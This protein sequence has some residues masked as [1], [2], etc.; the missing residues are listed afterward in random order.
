MPRYNRRG[1]T[2][3]FLVTSI[4]N[5]AAPTVAEI[6]AGVPLHDV[7]RAFNGFTSEIED[8]DAGDQG[9]TFNKTI[10]GGETAEAS[11]MTFYAGDAAADEE[12][13]VRAA[14]VEGANR[15]V[16]R[17]HWGAPV[18]AAPC[19]V[20]PVRIKASNDDPNGENNVT[21]T[22]TVGFSITDA[23]SKYVDIAA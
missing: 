7:L 5:Q 15:F 16:V 2:R 23:P 6:N 9:S 8:L 10:P 12:E 3:Y 14:L 19:D 21:A 13:A 17:C 1:K 4:A 22:Y 11:S 18:A 20:F